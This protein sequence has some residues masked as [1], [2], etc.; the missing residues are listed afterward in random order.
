MTDRLL[1]VEEAAEYLGVSAYTMREWARQGKVP[2][3][4][5]GRYWRFLESSLAGWLGAIERAAR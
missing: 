4:R 5:L 3:V 1:T 2:A